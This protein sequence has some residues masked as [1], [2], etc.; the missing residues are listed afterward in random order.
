[1]ELSGIWVYLSA[2]PL[3]WLVV[4]ISAYLLADRIALASGRNPLVNPVLISIVLVSALLVATGT[5][6]EAYFS[7]AQFVHFLLGPAIVALALPLLRN[8][9]AIRANL[10]PMLVALLVGG[11]VAMISAIGLALAF[12]LPHDMVAT[13]AP[14]S[15]TGAVAMGVAE[16]LGGDPSL[17]AAFVIVT[18]VIGAIMVTP[19]MNALGIRD[20]A[21]RGFAAGLAAHGIGTARALHVNDVAGAFAGIAMALSALFT[22]LIAPIVMA[23]VV[24]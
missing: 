1:M 20:Y 7:G 13:L 18:G 15:V 4:T 16:Q 22:A 3:F 14:K 12:G 11:L 5:S 8:L 24:G 9:R 17:A 21:A 19:L 6:Y 10:L 2:T 23:V